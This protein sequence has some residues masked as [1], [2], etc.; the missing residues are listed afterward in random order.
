VEPTW[1]PS[2]PRIATVLLALALALSI[3]GVTAAQVLT[4]RAEED[5]VAALVDELIESSDPDAAFLALSES[6]RRSVVA[7]HE[8]TELVS[9]SPL[10]TGGGVKSSGP[11]AAASICWT[12]QKTVNAVATRDGDDR[13]SAALG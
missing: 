10:V 12:F 7:F 5:Y 1:T 2:W 13:L 8:V 11:V 9:D 4:D 3:P 6:D